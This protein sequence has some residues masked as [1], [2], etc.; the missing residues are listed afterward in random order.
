MTETR[1]DTILDTRLG[2][3]GVRM[4]GG[5]VTE[6]E[7]LALAAQAGP[8]SGNGDAASV[9]SV[10]TRIESYL[11]DPKT[12]FD[13]PL[14]PRGSEFQRRVWAA[15]R[16]IPSGEVMTYGKLARQLGSGARAV[17][18]A[19]R[20]NP[21]PLL[22]PCHRVVAANGL[23]GYSGATE[24]PGIGLKRWLLRHEGAI[25]ATD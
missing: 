21:I 2:R 9:R 19:C 17:G 14:A 8:V 1:F 20:N 25:R 10:A 12:V 15:L 24:G 11:R 18:N 13:L 22:I 7:F 3:I 23:G 16:A 4:S 6:L 5:A